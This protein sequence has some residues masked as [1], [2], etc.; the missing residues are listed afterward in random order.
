MVRQYAEE[1]YLP[2]HTRRQ[3]LHGNL[4]RAQALTQWKSQV[5]L[6]WNQVQIRSVESEVPGPIT[7]GMQVPISASVDAWRP[8]TR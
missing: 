3:T 5:R 4:D 2:N 1:M 7:V 6:K 8:R